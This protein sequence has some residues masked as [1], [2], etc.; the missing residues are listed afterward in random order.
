MVLY[1]YLINYDLTAS[2]SFSCSSCDLFIVFCFVFNYILI[3]MSV[4]FLPLQWQIIKM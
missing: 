4:V 3:Q 2:Y 1:I